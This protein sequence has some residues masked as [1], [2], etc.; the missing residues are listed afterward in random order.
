MLYPFV[1]WV[2]GK[3]QLLNIILPLIPNN[4]KNYYEPFVGGGI[5]FMN[6]PPLN[7]ENKIYI[8]DINEELII[9]YFGIANYVSDIISEISTYKISSEFYYNLRK[10]DYRSILQIYDYKEAVIKI[11]S[12]M[13]YLNKTCFNGLYRVNSKGLFNSPFNKH[14]N[15]NKK[16]IDINNATL[17]SK[18]LKDN[19]LLYNKDYKNF[20]INTSY[21]DFVY[22]DPPYDNNYNGY[23]KYLFNSDNQLELSN[24]CKML[25]NKGVKW[26]LS[27]ND[28]EYIKNLYK[29]Y[30]ITIVKAR[31]NINC[32]GN[33]RNK[34]NELLIKN[35]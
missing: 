8:N 13:I 11:A 22:L 3:K 33:K 31:R 29:D 27:N 12:R 23:T 21:G 5:V 18:Y 25:D 24:V 35:Y 2:G 32:N 28:T 4:I 30:N 17:L 16:F 9:T 26:L 20:I 15:I 1:K 19:V 14:C 7:E 10:L 6:I 34:V